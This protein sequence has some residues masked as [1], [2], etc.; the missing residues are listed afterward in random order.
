MDLS[1]TDLDWRNLLVKCYKYYGLNEN[2]L[3]VILCVDN[4]LKSVKSII[5]PDDLVSYMTLS[6][7][8]IDSSLSK[9]LDKNMLDVVTVDGKKVSTLKPLKEKMLADL[10]RDIV[11]DANEKAKI[12]DNAKVNSIY[13]YFEDLL[14]RPLTGRETD[15]ISIWFKSGADE[16][17]IKEAVEKLKAQSKSI[18]FA[19]VDKVL[20]SIQKNGDINKE[21]FSPRKDDW[22][23]GSEETMNILS[24]RWV[25]K[26]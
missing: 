2:D 19:A 26:D 13:S 1:Y 23:E 24:K 20:L 5:V 3:A 18:S 4:V 17:M 15:K 6:K 9:L 22:R 21:G 7:D 14:G 12:K 16:R 10:R 25:P 11:I 8:D